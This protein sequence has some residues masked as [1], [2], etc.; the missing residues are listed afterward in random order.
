MLVGL[1]SIAGVVAI[2]S[3]IPILTKIV[4]QYI[5]PFTLAC[6]RLAQGL[7]VVLVYRKLRTGKF[8]GDFKLD[9]WSLLGGIGV[10]INYVF[11]VVSLN[12]TTVGMGALVVQVQFVTLAVLAWIVLKERFNILKGAA[13][14]LIIGGASLAFFQARG[15]GPSA[16]PEHI[17]GNSL[18]LIGG[19]GW[20]MHALANKATSHRKS[21]SDILSPVLAAGVVVSLVTAIIGFEIRSPLDIRGVLSIAFLGIAATGGGFLLLS[22]SLKRL[23]ASLTGAIT[24]ITPL[25]N[26][27][28]AKWFLNE[29]HPPTLFLGASVVIA[30]ILLMIQ[31]DRSASKVRS[32]PRK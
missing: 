26:M 25:L 4:L 1:L 8:F 3:T 17:L 19:L 23:N 16:R 11:F 27:L 14:I 31:A 21:I 32:K 5:D 10:S 7:A 2:W 6:L 24:S 12:F 15:V 18:M 13:V 30:G 9:W 20:G 28:L 22:V 29:S